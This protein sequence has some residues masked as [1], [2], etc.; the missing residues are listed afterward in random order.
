M[1][2]VSLHLSSRV[3][4]LPLAKLISQGKNSGMEWRE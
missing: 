4:R 3:H 1:S 2:E